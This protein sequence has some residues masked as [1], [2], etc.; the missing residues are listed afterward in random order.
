ML[1]DLHESGSREQDADMV[2]SWCTVRTPGDA[3]DPRVGG[4]LIIATH[5]NGPTTTVAVAH[6][7][8]LLAPVLIGPGFQGLHEHPG[9]S[10]GWR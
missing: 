6:Q 7:A 3:D 8:A 1:T 9:W 4:G 2:I 10:G 5:R